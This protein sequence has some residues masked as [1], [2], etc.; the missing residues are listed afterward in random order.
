MQL[1][2]KILELSNSPNFSLTLDFILHL[3]ILKFTEVDFHMF[4]SAVSNGKLWPS[5]PLQGL[6]CSYLCIS[7]VPSVSLHMQK[8]RLNF[9]TQP[10]PPTLC[11]WHLVFH[12]L[13]V[14]VGKSHSFNGARDI[15]PYS[16]L[17]QNL[18]ISPSILKMNACHWNCYKLA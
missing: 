17:G 2:L 15:M 11:W 13:V 8:A 18:K 9:L 12:C 6:L 1:K 5:T 4:P 10:P 16:L 14:G 3:R 7:E